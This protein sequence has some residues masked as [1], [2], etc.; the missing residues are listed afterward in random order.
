MI[1]DT[2]LQGF[3]YSWFSGFGFGS[4]IALCSLISFLGKAETALCCLDSLRLCF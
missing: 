3:E 2:A 1:S 4:G